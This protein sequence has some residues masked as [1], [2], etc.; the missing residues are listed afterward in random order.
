MPPRK[1]CGNPLFLQWMEGEDLLF[2]EAANDQSL[3]VF[4]DP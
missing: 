1:K 2:Y 4:R 3:Y